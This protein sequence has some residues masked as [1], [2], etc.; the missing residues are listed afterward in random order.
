AHCI[1]NG[2]LGVFAKGTLKE[3]RT[4]LEFDGKYM[5]L[6]HNVD[7]RLAFVRPDMLNR[8][9]DR[10]LQ[11]FPF[12][13]FNYMDC[14]RKERKVTEVFAFLNLWHFGQLCLLYRDNQNIWYC[15]EINHPVL[16]QNAPNLAN[17]LQSLLT[18]KPMHMSL[19][20]FLKE[21]GVTLEDIQFAAW[22]NPNSVITPHSPAQAAAKERELASMFEQVVRKV[23]AKGGPMQKLL[24]A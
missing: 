23:H 9:Y 6:G 21:K 2:Y 24:S 15:D 18:A 4:A 17:N 16:F 20:N 3:H 1:L 12:R 10:I 5:D 7:N 11:V 22:V 14:I 13:P 8:I 19:A